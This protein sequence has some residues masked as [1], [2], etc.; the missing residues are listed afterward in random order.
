VRDGKRDHVAGFVVTAAEGGGNGRKRQR[1]AGIIFRSL[2]AVV[3][4]ERRKLRRMACTEERAD[5]GFPDPPEKP[6]WR[7]GYVA[8]SRTEGQLDILRVRIWRTTGIGVIETRGDG[9]AR[10]RD[11]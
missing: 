2:D 7:S 11:S 6:R 9:V 4:I 8:L 3:A 1:N 5:W 10:R